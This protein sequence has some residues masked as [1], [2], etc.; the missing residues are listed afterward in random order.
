MAHSNMTSADHGLIVG[1]LPKPQ[2]CL[3]MEKIYNKVV[4]IYF[5][6]AD[7]KR[8]KI[9]HF[10]GRLSAGLMLSRLKVNLTD[11]GRLLFF[12]IVSPPGGRGLL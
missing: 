1:R 2:N 7:E 8:A 12:I 6:S 11:S 4:I 3:P 5:L 9:W 10:I